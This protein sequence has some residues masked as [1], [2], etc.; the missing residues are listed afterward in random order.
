MSHFS[1]HVKSQ[2]KKTI[3]NETRFTHLQNELEELSQVL[4]DRFAL[5]YGESNTR[6]NPVNLLD[7]LVKLQD[8]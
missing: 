5:Q 4:H 7:R 1:F 2:N 8:K 6:L 3:T